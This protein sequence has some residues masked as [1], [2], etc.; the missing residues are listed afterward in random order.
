MESLKNIDQ[1]AG[2]EDERIFKG[3]QSLIRRHPRERPIRL[4]CRNSVD[5][6][7]PGAEEAVQP[8]HLPPYFMLIHSIS[9]IQIWSLGKR[10]RGHPHPLTENRFTDQAWRC[11]SPSL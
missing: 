2:A 9:P 10:G 8:L 4:T 11:G 1:L 3:D 7:V 6:I 5:L